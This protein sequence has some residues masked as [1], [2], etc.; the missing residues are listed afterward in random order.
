M[1]I[2]T[3]ITSVA[4]NILEAFIYCSSLPKINSSVT[5]RDRQ[6]EIHGQLKS[7]RAGPDRGR[8][9]CR[10]SAHFRTSSTALGV[11][12]LWVESFDIKIK[13]NNNNNYYYCWTWLIIFTIHIL[14][15]E[16]SSV[17]DLIPKAR[18]IRRI[19]LFKV[20]HHTKYVK[21]N[22][23]FPFFFEFSVTD[24]DP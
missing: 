3:R 23:E 22:V 16:S 12:P 5:V 4:L 14:L 9:T 15:L 21:I 2:S 17:K 19:N 6:T 18:Y 8:H 7:V 1:Y 11:Y 10:P 24:S 13:P 20:V